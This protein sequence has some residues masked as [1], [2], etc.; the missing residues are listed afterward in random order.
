MDPGQFRSRCPNS[1]TLGLATLAGHRF[2]ITARGYASIEPHGGSL[3]HGVLAELTEGDEA[4][5]DHFE[6]VGHDIYRKASLALAWESREV[7]ALVY[8]DNETNHGNPRPGYLERVIRGARSHGL[9]AAV[10][11]S[12]EAWSR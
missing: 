9:P 6:G 8:I 2:I 4:A 3:V 1:R 10:I 5:L 12:I 11:T 7:A